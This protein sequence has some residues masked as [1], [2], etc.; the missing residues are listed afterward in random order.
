MVVA[1]TALVQLC[2]GLTTSSMLYY[3]NWVLG[4]S[5][6]SGATKQLLVN[7]IGQGP[8]GIG[9]VALWPLVRKYGKR[10][11]TVIGF[12]IAS[13]GSLGVL[14]AGNRLPLVLAALFMKSVGSLPS[15]VMASLLAEAL[16]HIEWTNGFRS[17]GFSASVA[18]ITQTTVMGLSQT[19]LLLGITVFGYISPAS[20]TTCIT[21]PESVRQFFSVCFAGFPMIGYA[22][23][24]GIM[25]FYDLEKHMVRIT[26]EFGSTRI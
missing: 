16:D 17:D 18:S 4:N 25:A 9:V 24:A 13:L 15:Y 19:V 26:E 3:C 1:F 7:V 11:V 8:L 2:T 5:V 23:G 6:E 14:L 12:S 21:Q 10:R 22:L 20:T